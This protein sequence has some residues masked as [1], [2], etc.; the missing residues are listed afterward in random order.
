MPGGIGGADQYNYFSK[1]TVKKFDFVF[2]CGLVWVEEKTM[3]IK[4]HNLSDRPNEVIIALCE[5]AASFFP[6][7]PGTVPVTIKNAKKRWYGKS[8]TRGRCYGSS[9]CIVWVERAGLENTYPVE[10]DQMHYFRHANHDAVK[11]MTAANWQEYFLGVVAHELEHTT[12]GNSRMRRSRQEIGAWNRGVAVVEASRTPEA[13]AIIQARTAEIIASG[14]KQVDKANFKK[15]P[16]YK[17]QQCE[18]L[19]EKWARKAKLASTK[20]RKLK[21]R[22]KYFEKRETMAANQ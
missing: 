6:H 5:F 22:I 3:R 21:M 13:Q 4:V 19:M 9:R 17:R 18:K 1:I 7:R 8:A 2:S 14:Q 12:K 10:Y 15:S 20:I 16:E 11:T